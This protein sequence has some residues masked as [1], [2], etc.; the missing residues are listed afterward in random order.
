MQKLILFSAFIF[1]FQNQLFAQNSGIS[2]G[3]HYPLTIPAEKNN[4]SD[5]NGTF[6]MGFQFQFTDDEVFNYGLEY[7]FD[8]NQTYQ[9]YDFGSSQ[10][11]SFNFM[12]NHLN[13]FTKINLDRA[14]NIKFYTDA[15]FT[16]YKYKEGQ[17][18]QGFTGFN[19]GAGLNYEFIEKFYFQATY[20]YINTGIKQQQT[21]FID[22]ENFNLFR[23]GIGF[24]I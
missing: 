7:E 5:V 22:K 15:G 23:I 1:Q 12:M 11:D 3:L 21:G 4:Y 17:G 2:V 8:M 10:T 16:F 9:R 19:V 13:G 20:H 6:G 24:K 14:Q 18:Q